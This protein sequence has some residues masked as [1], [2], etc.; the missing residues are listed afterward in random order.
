MKKGFTLIEL[1]VVIAI[2]GI[3]ATISVMNFG[4]IQAKSRDSQRKSDL[5]KISAAME[6]YKVDKKSYPDTIVGG[7]TTWMA[8]N[9]PLFSTQLTG[10]NYISAIPSNPKGNP[11]MILSNGKT[12]KILV[13]SEVVLPSDSEE[14]GRKK[15]GDYYDRVGS[16]CLQVSPD[17]T[18]RLSEY[19]D[20]CN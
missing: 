14:E 11:Y 12:Y 6:L 10:G 16:R 2:I 13:S 17:T 18:Y 1:L 5:S 3:L 19:S 20:Y 15:A 8:V 7:S 9:N 4:N